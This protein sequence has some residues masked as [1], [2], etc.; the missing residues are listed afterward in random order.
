MATSC[1]IRFA[2]CPL[3]SPR[4]LPA[5]ALTAYAGESNRQQALNAGFQLHLAKPIEPEKL[6][7]AIGD[8]LKPSGSGD[9]HSIQPQ[10]FF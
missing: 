6:V 10:T 8:L 4:P 5:I 9:R 7:Q 3:V 2:R 1:S